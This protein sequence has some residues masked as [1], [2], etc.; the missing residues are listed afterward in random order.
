[1]FVETEELKHK[2]Q[3]FE[4]KTGASDGGYVEVDSQLNDFKNKIVVSGAFEL[5]N[6]LKNVEE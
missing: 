6:A 2:Y 4:I 1:V 5:L 3:L